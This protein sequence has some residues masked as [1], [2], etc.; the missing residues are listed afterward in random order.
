MISL[1]L[2]IASRSNSEEFAGGIL[3][4]VSWPMMFLSEVWF[5]LEGAR[6]WVQKFSL[7][8]PLTHMVSGARK[9][10]NDGVSIFELQTQ[11]I[12]LTTMSIFFL[13]TG[14]LLFKWHKI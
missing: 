5:S 9:I 12:V 14:S 7:A 4:I 13:L 3:N 11:I 10:M 6:P 8:F 2:L 1:A